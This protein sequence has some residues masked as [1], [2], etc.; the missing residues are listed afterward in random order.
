MPT[1]RFGPH[2]VI[3][4]VPEGLVLHKFYGEPVLLPAKA[5]GEELVGKTPFTQRQIEAIGQLEK[6]RLSR[7]LKEGTVRTFGI[8]ID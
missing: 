3:P 1:P 7:R 6:E 2:V 4:E 5:E 8:Y